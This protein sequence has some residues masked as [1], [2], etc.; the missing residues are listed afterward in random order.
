MVSVAMKEVF[1]LGP[2]TVCFKL[3]AETASKTRAVKAAKI[4]VKIEDGQVKAEAG[5]GDSARKL[6]IPTLLKGLV[7]TLIQLLGCSQNRREEPG[8]LPEAPET[9]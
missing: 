9:P 1:R 3:Q 6:V 4:D 5:T 2:E 7:G 8:L